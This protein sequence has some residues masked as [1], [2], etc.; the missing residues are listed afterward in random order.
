MTEFEKYSLIIAGFSLVISLGA[1]FLSGRANT[2]SKNMFK[3]QG[4]IDL[5]MAWTDIKDIDKN[6]LIGPDIIRAVNAMSLTASLWNHDVIE[7]SI[8]YQ[9]YWNSYKDLYDTLININELVPGHKRTCRS[10]ITNE[11]AKAYEG[12]KNADLATVTQTNL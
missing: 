10:L 9:T 12:M 4:V 3:R 2:L 1:I 11:I 5:H 6:N 8:L 7:K